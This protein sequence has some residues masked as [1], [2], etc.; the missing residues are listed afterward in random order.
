MTGLL[1]ERAGHV[2]AVE[3]DTDLTAKLRLKFADLDNVEV[4]GAD[5]LEVDIGEICRRHGTAG[6]FVFGNLPYY[7]TSPILHH[8]LESPEH[9]RAMACVVQLE[10]AERIA[11]RPGT[12]DYGYLSVLAQLH[13]VPQIRFRILPGAFSPPPRV[14]SALVTFDALASGA[15]PD[16][17]QEFLEFSKHAFARKRKTL[18]NNLAAQYGADRVR[19]ELR[20]LGIKENARAEEIGVTELA[21]LFKKLI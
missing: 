3:L 9:I 5:I 10:V 17:R 2:V 21:S 19:G 4:V 6:A 8:L 13:S 11:A 1:A 12:R 15:V 16:S 7:I 20:S 18:V 14:V